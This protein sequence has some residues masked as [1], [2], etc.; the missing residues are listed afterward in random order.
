LILW[1]IAIN[2]NSGGTNIFFQPPL[3]SQYTP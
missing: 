2:T 1:S 3:F